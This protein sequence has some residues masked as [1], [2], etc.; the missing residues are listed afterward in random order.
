M[1]GFSFGEAAGGIDGATGLVFGALALFW[2]GLLGLVLRRSL[3]GM[4][5]GLGF[6][7]ASVAGL[8]IAVG[9]FQADSE[10]AV[11]AGGFALCAAIAGCLQVAVGLALVFARVRRRGSIDAEEARLLEG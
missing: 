5:V 4:L 3:V 9:L 8:G 1:I 6:A 10:A 11:R 7:W 2:V